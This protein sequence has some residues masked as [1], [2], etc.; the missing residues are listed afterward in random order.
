MAPTAAYKKRKVDEGM[1]GRV[2]SRPSK[3]FKKQKRYE[4]DSDDSEEEEPENT[5]FK[6]VTLED[7]DDE[8]NDDA[9]ADESDGADDAAGESEGDDESDAEEE[10]SESEASD[11]SSDSESSRIQS[12]KRKRN[13]PEAFANSMTKILGSKLS[14]SKRADPVL[15]RSRTAADAAHELS[16]SRLEAKAKHKM[17][18]E[19][20]A[21][22]DRGRVKDVLGLE[23]A[24]AEGGEVSVAE[25][26][27]LERRLKKTAQRGVVKLFNAVRA[28]QVKAEEIAKQ[29]QKDGTVGVAKREE[30]V[31]EM[32][33]KGF[34]DLIASGGKKG[35]G[36]DIE[37]A[38]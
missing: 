5:D 2:T 1:K 27:E 17:R 28:A 32:S 19:K 37:E 10:G 26:I 6:P 22:L 24:P 30:K 31:N 25:T 38:R 9:P 3:K 12:K 33:R 13:D 4:S 15:A 20:K 29:M 36:A 7:S 16:N 11:A 21:Q 23:S 8:V 34:L 14:T 18:E 35:L